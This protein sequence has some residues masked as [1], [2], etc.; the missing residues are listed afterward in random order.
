MQE[1]IFSLTDIHGN[2]LLMKVIG[3]A[4]LE[5][6][7]LLLDHGADPDARNDDGETAL[8]IV[9]RQD[10]DDADKIRVLLEAG[11]DLT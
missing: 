10:N 1:Q 3:Y 8:M 6:V 9:A 2:T 4:D 7:E 5:F 11:A